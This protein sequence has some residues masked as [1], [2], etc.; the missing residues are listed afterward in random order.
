MLLTALTLQIRYGHG[1]HWH[2]PLQVRHEVLSQ[3]LR[4]LQP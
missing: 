3:Q 4:V 1:S 2:C